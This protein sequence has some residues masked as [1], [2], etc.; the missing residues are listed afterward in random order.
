[1]A[2]KKAKPSGSTKKKKTDR[3][4]QMDKA[5]AADRLRRQL[6]TRDNR[7]ARQEAQYQEEQQARRERGGLSRLAVF[8]EAVR[9]AQARA[10]DRLVAPYEARETAPMRARAA[11][12][13]REFTDSLS[14]MNKGGVATKSKKVGMKRGGVVTKAGASNPATQKRTPKK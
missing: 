3:D 14:R 1:M 11:E 9:R 12:A 6:D 13:D 7:S 4:E 5:R 10:A 2:D 8:P